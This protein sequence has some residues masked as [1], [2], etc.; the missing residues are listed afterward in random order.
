M[1]RKKKSTPTKPSRPRDPERSRALRRLTLK[2]IVSILLA[3]GLAAGYYYLHQQV[4]TRIAFNPEPPQVVLVNRPVWMSDFL[5]ATIAE[6]IRPRTGS[7]AIDHQVVV[8]CAML[9]EAD[10][11]VREVR[12]VRRIYGQGPGDTIEIDCEY[13]APVA[14]V[15]YLNHYVLVDNEG[16]VLPEQFN[17]E[18]ISRI[19]YGQNG[20]MNIRIIEGV[21]R[22]QPFPGEHWQ[23][24]DLQAGLWMARMLHGKPYANE[25][26]R[27]D[28]SNY[29]GR[30]NPNEAHIVLHTRYDTQVRWG[31]PHDWRGFEA[32]IAKK[33]ANLQHIFERYGRVDANQPWIDL[34]FDKVL[35]PEGDAI[36]T[37]SAVGR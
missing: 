14:L 13:R 8:D 21:A 16:V 7:S 35:R 2:I 28:V 19:V 22:R 25:I 10:P 31:Q 36:N 1:A 15:K 27:V 3:G 29:A 11:W 9:A 5:A 26:L 24:D 4:R 18:D 30:R 33:L 37:A 32:P 12:Q 17:E 34:R 20:Q 6:R 23:G